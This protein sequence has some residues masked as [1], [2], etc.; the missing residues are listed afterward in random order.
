MKK[1]IFIILLVFLTLPL[2][3]KQPQQAVLST[4]QEQ[5]FKYYWYA[6]KQAIV[7]DRYG[8]AYVLLN[9]CNAI[10]PNDGQTLTYLGILE[11]GIGNELKGLILLQ[12]AF[13]ADPYDQWYHYSKELLEMDTPAA[14]IEAL[15]VLEKAHEVQQPDC[16]ENLLDQ[17]QDVYLEL[18][19]WDEAIQIQ[20]E[21]DRI[22]GYN[23][24]SALLRMRIALVQ[25][26]PKK[27]L[28]EA[29]KYLEQDPTDVAILEFKVRILTFLKTKPKAFYALYDRILELD[30]YNMTILN[31]YA[32]TLAT[33]KGDLQKAEQMSATTIKAEPQ[34]AS[35]LDTYGWIMYLKGENE[36][37]LFY[38]Y[39][40][41]S[42]ATDE[43]E[44]EIKEHIQIVEKAIQKRDKK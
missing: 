5:Q 37:A 2:M 42:E 26:Q 11:R 39:R 43:N 1:R 10:N 14:K 12:K 28:K 16:D 33:N 15:R 32:W 27:A 7:E 29:N 24:Q 19:K 20:D 8:E 21:L 3:A 25:T 17:L 23:R 13:E 40:A 35:F 38:L 4:E 41:K 34:N 6:A 9:F 31:D 30:P 44:Q 36:L 22:N 18:G